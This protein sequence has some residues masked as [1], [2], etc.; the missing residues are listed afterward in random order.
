MK[1]DELNKTLGNCLNPLESGRVVKYIASRSSFMLPTLS[2]NPLESGRVVKLSK[3]NT[4]KLLKASLNPLES[5]R[6]V[7]SIPIKP[8]VKPRPVLIPLNRVVL[9]NKEIP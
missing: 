1:K 7:K 8:P 3:W 2:L 4:N 6:V 9:L 5:G